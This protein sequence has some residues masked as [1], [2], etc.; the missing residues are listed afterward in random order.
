MAVSF[1]RTTAPLDPVSVVRQIC[2]EAYSDP[3]RQRSRYVK[4]LTPARCMRK[5]LGNGLE[6]LC[7]IVLGPVFGD[8]DVGKKVIMPD[9]QQYL[10]VG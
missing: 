10:F 8:G 9:L 1:V 6:Q 3:S 2:E 5:T 4:R 7:E